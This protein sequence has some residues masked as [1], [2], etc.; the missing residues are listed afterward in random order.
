[1]T[2]NRFLTG[3]RFV[4][5]SLFCV[6]PVDTFVNNKEDKRVNIQKMSRDTLQ[7]LYKAEPS[8][9][10]A[11]EKSYGYAVF[12]NTPGNGVGMAVNNKTKGKTF[13]RMFEIHEGHGAGV[14]KFRYVFVFDNETVFNDSVNSG[15]ESG[16][17]VSEAA[18]T[19]AEK[20]GPMHGAAAVSNGIWMYQLNGRGVVL[21]IAAKSTKYSPD[22]NLNK[23]S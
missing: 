11:V 12:S 23:S 19:S 15:W 21:N 13:M 8:A 4:V 10:T 14:K 7:R 17:Q 22:D 6:L 16:G 20:G 9:K 2:V 18:K 1:M 5:T 3:S